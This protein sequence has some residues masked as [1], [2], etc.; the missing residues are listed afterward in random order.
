MRFFSYRDRPVHLG[1]YPLERL[2]RGDQLPDFADVPAMRALSFD[3]PDP[4]SLAHA[5]ARCSTGRRDPLPCNPLQERVLVALPPQSAV[6][7]TLRMV[8]RSNILPTVTRVTSGTSGSIDQS[9]L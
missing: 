4:E 9:G 8:F 1:P 5:M 3:H 2:K 6:G 7:A